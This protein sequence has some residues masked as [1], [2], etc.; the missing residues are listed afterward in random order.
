MTD[1]NTDLASLIEQLKKDR[2]EQASK[3]KE[4]SE[5][6]NSEKINSQRS[7]LST[8]I[9]SLDDSF[10]IKD[11]H[12]IEYLTGYRDASEKFTQKINGMTSEIKKI[13][14]S[15]IPGATITVPIAPIAEYINTPIGKK[16]KSE[17]KNDTIAIRIKNPDF[18][19][20]KTVK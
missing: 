16:L 4:L 6:L 15:Y 13:N 20:E 18:D 3:I 5:S 2:D 1:T 7:L 19:E 17:I 11:E 12:S 8:K 10:A 9:N 14:S